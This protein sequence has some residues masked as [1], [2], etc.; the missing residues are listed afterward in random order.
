MIGIRAATVVIKNNKVL[1]VKSK[2]SDGEYYLFPGGGVEAKETVEQA[3]IRETLEETGINVKIKK[4]IH[5]NEYIDKSDRS[6]AIFF[7]SEEIGIDKSKITSDNG[8][9]L[10]IEWIDI[11]KLED[12]TVHPRKL[13]ELLMKHS[14]NLEYS[15][16]YKK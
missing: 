7:L 2:Y 9:I 11:N 1:L 15:V 8:K 13:V 3:A 5:I 4:L 16:D 10:G 12:I 14:E 6:I